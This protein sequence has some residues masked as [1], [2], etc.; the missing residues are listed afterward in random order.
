M[1]TYF[2]LLA[3]AVC[4]L[5]QSAAQSGKASIRMQGI[6][7][8]R[9]TGDD[10]FGMDG[11]GDEI[12]L[13]FNYLLNTG[14]NTL[15]P[16]RNISCPVL[17]EVNNFMSYSEKL[18]REKAGTVS[19][20][21]GIKTGD[22]YSFKGL[23]YIIMDQRVN[24]NSLVMICPSIWEYDKENEATFPASIYYNTV[25]AT[26]GTIFF[27]ENIRRI[28]QNPPYAAVNNENFQIPGTTAGLDNPLSG[29]LKS[30]DG[31]LCSRPVGVDRNNEYKSTLLVFNSRMLQWLS[32]KDF[33]YGAGFVPVSFSDVA[34][35]NTRNHGIYTMLLKVDYTPDPVTTPA[36]PPPPPPP[37]PPAPINNPPIKVAISENKN[38]TLKNAQPVKNRPAASTINGTWTG[39]F[40]T[41][42]MIKQGA[43]HVQ[44]N[45]DGTMNVQN[46]NGSIIGTGNYTF[47]NDQVNGSC[48]ISGSEL[49]SFTGNLTGST[50]TG[51]WGMNKNQTGSGNWSLT[52]Q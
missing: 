17:G 3:M 40:L 25:K 2:L 48:T 19:A 9:E 34:L 50:L 38:L 46:T 1:K 32:T 8:T 47:Q 26:M 42:K 36:P 31:K 39:N 28:A 11:V 7:C 27:Q 22:T 29:M 4:S 33:G 49:L 16:A 14:P 5:Q 44:F 21:G 45:A 6:I 10:I 35:G 30:F 43:T 41:G 13:N 18:S 51:T 24:T 23:R 37:P 20:N 12:Y 52:R 15:A